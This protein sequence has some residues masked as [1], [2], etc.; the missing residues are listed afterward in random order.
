MAAEP[1]RGPLPFEPKRKRKK[2]ADP[3]DPKPLT[4]TSQKAASRPQAAQ[5]RS[6]TQIPEVIS[7]RMLKRMLV[8]SGIPTGLGVAAFFVSYILLIRHILELPNVV[9]LLTT[10][11]CFGLGV[12]GLSYGALSASWDEQ[13]PGQLLGIEE[14]RTNFGRLTQA[15]R[16]SRPTRQAQADKDN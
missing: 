12:L 13:S 3:S 7:R 5:N 16:D 15:W 8:F 9:V 6:D 4:A 10:L 2:A 11:G 14:F 1:E